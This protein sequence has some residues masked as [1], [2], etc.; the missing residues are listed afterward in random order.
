[1][2][3]TINLF[4]I[5]LQTHILQTMGLQVEDTYFANKGQDQVSPFVLVYRRQAS[6]MQLWIEMNEL[7]IVLVDTVYSEFLA[8]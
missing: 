8:A 7:S 6:E 2:H 5:S 1:M 4:C 3:L